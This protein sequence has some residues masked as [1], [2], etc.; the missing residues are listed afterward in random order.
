MA[1]FT[2]DRAASTFGAQSHGYAAATV[3]SMGQNHHLGQ[4]G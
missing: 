1:T 3:C 4:P 2:G